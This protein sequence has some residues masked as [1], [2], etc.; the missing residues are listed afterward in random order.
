MRVRGRQVYEYYFTGA[1]LVEWL[2]EE[3]LA[4][5]PM[6]AVMVCSM[7]VQLGVIVS[8]AKNKEFEGKLELYALEVGDSRDKRT[9]S[10]NY[11]S[12]PVPPEGSPSSKASKKEKKEKKKKG[13]SPVFV[14]F[15]CPSDSS[16]I[17]TR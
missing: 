4:A 5:T 9:R 3:S 15:L 7:L 12:S 2:L 17:N 13:T 14:L 6:D 16:D 8:L 10:V 11:A 1:R